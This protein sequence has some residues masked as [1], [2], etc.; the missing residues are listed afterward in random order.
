[1]EVYVS[2][3]VNPSQFWLQIVG[4][5]ANELDQLV[6]EMTDYYSKQ[7][8]KDLHILTNISVGEIV[9]A[10]F[11]FDEKWYRAEV[12]AIK[13]I[14]DDQQVAQ[15]YYVDYGDSDQVPL[16]QIFELRTDFLRLRFQAIECY[17][18]RVKPASSAWTTEAIDCFD[19]LTHLA[20]WKK[21]RARVNGYREKD[22]SPY[23]RVKREG[24]PVPGVDLYDVTQLED[25]DLGLELVRNGYAV[26]EEETVN[27]TNNKTDEAGENISTN[28]KNC[29]YVNNISLP[30]T[31]KENIILERKMTD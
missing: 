14:E 7:E 29:D 11:T 6:E 26:F 3:A 30:G 22:S 4:P 13:T 18:A 31:S 28:K 8:N 16:N 20:Q 25:I 9:A 2:A 10:V 27:G 19:E 23:G 15:L 24:S 17:L 21:L 12:V 1:M 5:N